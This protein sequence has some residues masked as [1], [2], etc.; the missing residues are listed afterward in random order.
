[1]RR[2]HPPP[3]ITSPPPLCSLHLVF[4][5]STFQW[6]FLPD[7]N[8][9]IPGSRHSVNMALV[10]WDVKDVNGVN[11]NRCPSAVSYCPSLFLS[12]VLQSWRLWMSGRAVVL[13]PDGRQFDPSRPPSACWSVLG[14]RCWNPDFFLKEKK[15]SEE[16]HCMKVSV[17][18]WVGDWV[19]GK[20]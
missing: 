10:T 8:D 9:L 15:F 2:P 11:A 16:M 4:I 7:A 1:M 20:L 18:G 12:I 19:S 17:N 13:Q 5:A 3:P 6:E 14:A